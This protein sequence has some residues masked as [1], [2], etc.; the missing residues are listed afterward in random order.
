MFDITS[1]MSYKNV[2]K[3]HKDLTRICDSIP[4]ILVGNIVKFITF[5]KILKF[6]LVKDIER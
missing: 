6:S 5:N 4:I 3:W 2:P 1:R